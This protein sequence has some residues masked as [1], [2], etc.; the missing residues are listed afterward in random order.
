MIDIAWLAQHGPCMKFQEG[1]VIPCPGTGAGNTEK[2]MYI[3]LG[4]R[5]D[6]TGTPRKPAT[7]ISLF[8]GDVFGGEE[9]FKNRSE[10][11]Y[12]AAAD[13]VVYVITESSFSDLSWSQPETVFAVLRAAYIPQGRPTVKTISAMGKQEKAVSQTAVGESAAKPQSESDIAKASTIATSTGE[14]STEAAA[15][16]VGEADAVAAVDGASTAVSPVAI[17]VTGALFPQGHKS[18]PGVTKPE[19]AA[20]VY[21]KEYSCPNCKQKFTDYK[22]FSS[23][24]YE[25]APMRYDMRKFY[26]DFQTEWYDIVTCRHCYFSTVSAYYTESR[27]LLKQKIETQ[28]TE[29]RESLILDFDSE[30][31]IDFV[32]SAH[33]LA[34]VCADGYLSYAHPLKAKIWGN[35]SWLYED[36]E[37]KE[38][39]IFAADKAA[40]AYELVFAESRL[41]PVGE[42]TTCLSI[43]GMQ[44]RAG[45]DR[46][47]KKYL[48]QVKTAKMGEKAYIIMAED[49]MEDMRS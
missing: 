7:A 33:Y 25:S 9:Y 20:L 32:F 43:A 10:K 1:D 27:P 19:F 11:V 30:R 49:L 13:C 34:L 16:V 17:P 41:T 26:K 4:G 35:L 39:E 31:E 24:L 40:A 22:I 23:K 12:T 14:A 6:V 8:P 37:D 2:A 15:D 44:M 5:V 28:L 38:M 36:V 42:Q 48:Y 21:E 45:I 46:D 3:L 18:Y 29:A 47:M